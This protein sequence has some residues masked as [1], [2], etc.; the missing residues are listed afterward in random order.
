MKWLV[1]IELSEEREPEEI[2]AELEL[3]ISSIGSEMFESGIEVL[4]VHK[5]NK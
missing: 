1:E 3:A 4:E 2:K 5:V